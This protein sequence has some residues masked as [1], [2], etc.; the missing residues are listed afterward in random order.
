[1]FD[2]IRIPFRGRKRYDEKRAKQDALVRADF[3]AL[4]L[5]NSAFFDAY[6]AELDTLVDAMLEIEPVTV[7]SE[8]QILRLHARIRELNNLITILQSFA[9]QKEV[10]EIQ[11]EAA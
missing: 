1:M 4:V 3:A 8:R 6:Q 2:F 5:N 7:D 10:I 9:R 11:A